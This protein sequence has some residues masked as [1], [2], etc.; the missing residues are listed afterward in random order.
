M[1]NFNKIFNST[2]ITGRANV[3]KATYA[4]IALLYLY[5][6][7]RKRSPPATVKCEDCP[8]SN[9]PQTDEHDKSTTCDAETWQHAI[10]D[11]KAATKTSDHTT[12][13]IGENG[14]RVNTVDVAASG[15]DDEKDVKI[16]GNMR[17]QHK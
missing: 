4:S 16:L 15:G 1:S 8:V 10:E 2:T 6:R 13:L 12:A 9:A 3:A 5:Y 7:V 11:G 17:M 14:I